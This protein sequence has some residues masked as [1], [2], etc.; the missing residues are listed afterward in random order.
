VAESFLRRFFGGKP[1]VP[2]ADDARAEIDCALA[3]RPGLRGPLDWLRAVADEL[4][5]ASAF[6]TATLP[7]PDAARS[8][9]LGGV[10]LLR[11][12]SVTVDTAEFARRWKRLAEALESPPPGI[13]LAVKRGHLD[14]GAALATLLDGQPLEVA[15]F[16]AGLVVTLCRFTLFAGLAALADCAVSVRQGVP[17]DHGSCPVCGGTPLLGEF[18]G[19]DQSRFLRCGSCAASWEVPRQWCP[20]CG[21]R[22]HA[23]LGF[24]AK[25]GEGTRYRVATCDACRGGLK[26]LSTLTTLPPLM[27]LVADAATLHLDLAAADRGYLCPPGRTAAG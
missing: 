17:W 20:G 9:L 21:N 1:S 19:L 11:G 6:V 10:P 2:A 18:R 22:D 4:V 3:D 14:P 25:E 13:G 16:D 24:L 12:E 23:T 5:P 26:M 8:K 7:D 27:L 15:G